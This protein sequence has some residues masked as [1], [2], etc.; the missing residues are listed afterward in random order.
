[1]SRTKIVAT[2]GPACESPDVLSAM[3]RAGLDVARL[4]VSH[5]DPEDLADAVKHVR[6]VADQAGLPVAVLA[7]MPG[8]KIRCTT[9][10]PESFELND[11]QVIELASGSDDDVSTPEKIYVK[12]PHL[13][14]DVNEGEELAINDGLV[15]LRTESVRKD[16]GVLKC[17]VVSGGPISSR[18][19]VS[20]LQSNL[21]VPSLTER[22]I[23]GLEAAAKAHVDFIALSFVRSA[24]DIREARAILAKHGGEDIPLIAKIEQHEAV[25]AIEE[26]LE[27]AE[28]VMVARGDM[29][30]EQPLERVPLLQKDII[31]KANHAGRFVITATQML[32][33]MIVHS[34]PTRAEVTDV[35]NAILD[36]TDAVMLSAET[37]MGHD[38]ALAVNTMDRIAR[39]AEERIYPEDWV[40]RMGVMRNGADL[41]EL[42]DALARTSCRLA[43]DAH[44]DAIV[45]LSFFGTTG[46]RVARYRPDCPI[47]AISPH[48]NVCRRLCIAWGVEAFFLE[49]IS[50]KTDHVSADDLVEPVLGFFRERQLLKKGDRIAFLAGVPLHVPGGTNY[51]R[52]IE[53]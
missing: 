15:L 30:I 11:D 53:V 42:D 52:V 36:G 13:L 33:S 37:A 23:A 8:P 49:E 31:S 51:L 4:N 5:L 20:F 40:R 10:D 44:L 39:T 46:W 7:D 16:K 28:G 32:E 1:M 6:D 29:G 27:E 45:C 9:C 17:R 3:L 35:A 18:K 47:L 41:P 24:V 38:P 12:Y 22:D 50:E 48:E 34:R 43:I 14:E 19:G 26:I 21:R 2:Y 25:D